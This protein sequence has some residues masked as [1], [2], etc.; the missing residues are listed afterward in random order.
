MN[1]SHNQGLHRSEIIKK[2]KE[3]GWKGEK[4]TFAWKKLNGQRT[5]MWEIPIFKWVENREVKRELQKRQGQPMGA[6]RPSR[7]LR[8]V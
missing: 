4:L 8:R 2:L 5:G 7:E 1:N 3:M 6:M